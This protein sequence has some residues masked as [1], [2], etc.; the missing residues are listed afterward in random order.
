[1]RFSTGDRKILLSIFMSGIFL[2][3]LYSTWSQAGTTGEETGA[4]ETLL[5]VIGLELYAM[6]VSEKIEPEARRKRLV[7]LSRRFNRES[8]KEPFDQVLQIKDFIL[9]NETDLNRGLETDEQEFYERLPHV[10]PILLE[11]V[12][13]IYGEPGSGTPDLDLFFDRIG[14]NWFS[15]KALVR[16]AEQTGDEVM[17]KSYN[18]ALKERARA[19]GWRIG[20]LS[21]AVGL[22][23]FAGV[24]LWI[25]FLFLLLRQSERRV[26]KILERAPWNFLDG[27]FV[28]L[29]FFCALTAISFLLSPLYGLFDRW[30]I[31]VANL[32]PLLY[33]M[34]II[35]G[36]FLIQRFFFGHNLSKAMR[37]MGLI[38]SGCG[39]ARTLRWGLGGYA[40]TVPF[41]LITLYLSSVILR[42]EP[43]SSN[44]MIPMVI[45]ASSAVERVL[46]FVT[47]A[48]MAPLFEEIFFRG[49]LFNCF[50]VRFGTAGAIALSAFLFA[51]VHFDFS[52]FFGL[53]AIGVM[54]SFVY[55]RTQT[56][57]VPV[58]LHSLWNASTLITIQILFG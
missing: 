53:F 3:M 2:W 8:S 28:F 40:A 11:V 4:N 36:I 6:E 56:L 26:E 50:R 18:T 48:I 51:A 9:R 34:Q 7:S 52:V 22:I 1:M 21:L 5:R 31:S 16:Y 19:V 41:V 46:F 30:G 29:L 24:V 42:Q 14:R 32:T 33:L 39:P 15:W 44:P 13:N 49:F 23:I 27:Y 37:A 10:D 17:Q 35:V 57:L 25:R 43:V 54:L 55:Y 20:S 58:I 47:I 38:S 45:E 12:K